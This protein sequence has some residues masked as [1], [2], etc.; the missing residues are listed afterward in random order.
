MTLPAQAKQILAN[1]PQ[2]ASV[3]TLAPNTVQCIPA[4]KLQEEIGRSLDRPAGAA[5]LEEIVRDKKKIV[6]CVSDKTR[7]FPKNEMIRAVLERLAGVDPQNITFI[8]AGGNHVVQTAQ[9][10]GVDAD[11][12]E[13][14]NWVSHNSRDK[15]NVYIGKTQRRLRG[16]FGRYAMAETGRALRDLPADLFKFLWY[17]LSGKPSR[18]K[19][20]LGLH[21]GGRIG[22]VARSAAPTKVYVNPVV[23]EADLVITIGQV[24][25]HYFTG[26][27]G[28][29]KSILPAVS[30]FSTI[31]SNHCMRPHPAAT[32][33]VVRDNPIRLD[34]EDAARLAGDVFLFNC[35]L[36]GEGRPYKFLAGDLVQAH[37]EA[38]RSALEVGGVE[39]ERADLVVTS[40]GPP[41]DRSLYQFCKAI[42]PA[43]RVVKPRGVI[44][45]IGDC[46]EG[47][48]DRFI[49]NEIIFK[50]GFRHR[51]PRGVDLFLISK[52]PD[53][54]VHTTFFKP[55]HSL[56]QGLD[57]T[58]RKLK[59]E[60]SVNLIPKAGP[61]MPYLEGEN[62]AEW[63]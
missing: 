54:M 2:V 20:H 56:E 5:K 36:D 42:A 25:P 57:Y 7:I 60:F 62:P 16:F 17:P 34:M 48:G 39:A 59:R 53:K 28:G 13:G 31:A 43:I 47:I 12:A 49:I 1:H 58:A 21:V 38:S 45:A 33:G 3:A 23:K 52:M 24:K 61:M 6:V 11:L 4:D 32:L 41:V 46:S 44:V 63:I 26:Y 29:A 30:S 8:V 15:T 18:L 55:M 19:Y 10:A 27:S 40:A 35:V 50:L 14:H 9:E 22:A 37:R 51:I